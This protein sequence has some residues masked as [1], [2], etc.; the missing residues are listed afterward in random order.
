MAFQ[1]EQGIII[2]AAVV[3][4]IAAAMYE[5]GAMPM[6]LYK[7]L[8]RAEI[9]PESLLIGGHLPI[10]WIFYND[11][12]VNSRVWYDFGA[13]DS[14]VINIPLLNSC[15]K[16]IA[17]ASK[18]KYR[19]EVIDGLKGVAERLGGWDAL[20][21]TMR[22]T[23]A[24]VTQPEEDWIRNAFLAKYGGLWVSPSIVCMKPLEQLP[25]DKVVAYGEDDVP[26][27]G[28]SVPGFRMVWAPYPNHPIF[29]EGEMR[30]RN[31]LE[32]QLGGRQV[33]GDAKSD[34]VELTR[35]RG[36]IEVRAKEEQGRNPRTNKKLELE[37][38]F[39]SGTEGRLPFEISSSCV[40][41][42]IPYNDLLDRRMWGWVLRMSE[43][44]ILDSD[45]VIRYLLEKSL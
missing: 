20:P 8:G 39:A 29:A 38:L 21:K 24:Q 45:I 26:M 28:S 42:P 35:G 27:Y 19:I 3:L 16:T 32:H 4:V 43:E 12:E 11:S 2:G 36:D 40:Y 37:D 30:C 15:Y 41:I 17:M 33:R 22:N 44:Q 25:K 13:R 1:K 31:R 23:K 9:T 34:W 18:D 6:N 14:R 7:R 10:L 5:Y